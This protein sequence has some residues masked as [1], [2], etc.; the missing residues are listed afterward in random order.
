MVVSAYQ[1]GRLRRANGRKD[2]F[3][4]LRTIDLAIGWM[5]FKQ[6][7]VY[8]AW[9][10]QPYTMVVRYEDLSDDG[11]GILRVLAQHL[12]ISPTE[13]DLQDLVSDY[14]GQSAP[15]ELEL[16]SSAAGAVAMK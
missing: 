6:I 16:T 8:E 4:R 10:S 11:V 1:R 14:T 3:A 2:S 5:R 9:R 13:A 15:S 7:P 12:G